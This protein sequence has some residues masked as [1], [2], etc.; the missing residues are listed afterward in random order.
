MLFCNLSEIIWIR[1]RSTDRKGL[2]QL[3]SPV[4]NLFVMKLEVV[5]SYWISF[6]SC[7][8]K[9][10]TDNYDCKKQYHADK[11]TPSSLH[12]SCRHLPQE[13]VSLHV[14]ESR[15][16]YRVDDALCHSACRVVKQRSCEELSPS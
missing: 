5:Q 6:R 1:E 14:T 12:Q 9:K 10:Q 2:F 15:V 11:I 16:S 7:R 4:S 3:S 13:T 8:L